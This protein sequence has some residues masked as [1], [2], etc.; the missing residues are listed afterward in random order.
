[1]PQTTCPIAPPAACAP[2]VGR[3]TAATST[4]RHALAWLAAARERLARPWRRRAAI[5]ELMRLDDRELRDIGLLPADVEAVV[6][7][8]MRARR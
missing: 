4:A 5:R 8:L 6:D 2:A 1:M 7:A 3:T